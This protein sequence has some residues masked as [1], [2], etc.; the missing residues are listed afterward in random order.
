MTREEW[1]APSR[2]RIAQAHKRRAKGWTLKKIAARL[3]VGIRAIARYLSRP[4]PAEH[5]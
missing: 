3:G 5:A 4:D 2:K 1:L